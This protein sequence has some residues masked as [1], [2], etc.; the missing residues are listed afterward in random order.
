[1][2]QWEVSCM[3]SSEKT[4][5]GKSGRKT[6]IRVLSVVIAISVI[7]S[8]EVIAQMCFDTV[9]YAD[10][11]N[12]DIKKLVEDH[13][14]VGMVCIGASQV[15]HSCDTELLAERLGYEAVVDASVAS[16]TNDG[17]YYLLRDMLDK[18]DPDTVVINL[19]WDRFREKGEVAADRGRLLDPLP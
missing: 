15:Y 10:Y 17:G 7:A 1:M 12:Y 6:W 5:A 2:L 19:N 11:Y 4:A 18:F 8:V 14:D 9:R 16:Q 3:L 13:T